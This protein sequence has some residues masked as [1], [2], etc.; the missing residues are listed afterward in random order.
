MYKEDQ[1]LLPTVHFLVRMVFW[2]FPGI[3]WIE[4]IVREREMSL[5]SDLIFS[6][7]SL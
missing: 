3:H 6:I 2:L 7:T 4:I 5:P 1:E